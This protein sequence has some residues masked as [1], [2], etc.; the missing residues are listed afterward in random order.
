MADHG[1]EKPNLKIHN[2]SER[3]DKWY[4]GGGQRLLFA[5]PFPLWLTTP[6]FWDEAQFYEFRLSPIFTL[7]LL[8]E[9]EKPIALEVVERRWTPA[10]F[11]ITYRAKNFLLRESR[12]LLPPDTLASVFTVKNSRRMPLA[13]HAILWNVEDKEKNSISL[14]KVESDIVSYRMDVAG[15][16]WTA[17]S[18]SPPPGSPSSIL[19]YSVNLSERTAI[20]P[21]WYLTP[22][23]ESFHQHLPNQIQTTGV[24]PAGLLYIG[25]HRSIHIPGGERITFMA[26]RSFSLTLNG[27]MEAVKSARRQSDPVE[28]ARTWWQS[29]FSR[30]PTFSCSNPFIQASYLHRV[31]GLWLN[32]V[33]GGLGTIRHP[34]V[35]EGISYFRSPIAYSAPAQVFE[36]RWMKSSEIPWGILLNFIES[37]KTDGSFYGILRLFAPPEEAFYHANWGRALL[38]LYAIH[39]DPSLLNIVYRALS[40]YAKYFDEVRDL[41]KSGLY[42]VVNHFETGQE[43]MSRYTAVHPTADAEN[44]GSVFRLK[45]VDATV[46]IYELKRAL[47]QAA[48]LLKKAEETEKWNRQADAIREA[49]R[50]RMWNQR[51]GMFSD[52]DPSTGQKTNIK[53]AI[54]F[55]PYL[56]DIV[57]KPHVRRLARHLFNPEEFWTPFPVPATSIDDRT[58]SPTPEWKGKRHNCPWNG[59]V[60]PM[61]NSHIADALG[62]VAYHIDPRF[63][64]RLA[65]FLLRYLKMLFW[66]EDVT[67]PNCYEHYNPFTGEPSAYRGIDDYMHSWVADLIIQYIAGF[68]P[69]IERRFTVDP[70]PIPL[71]RLTIENIPFQGHRITIKRRRDEQTVYVDGKRVASPRVG[72]PFHHS[73]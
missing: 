49:I 58:F 1:V 51:T 57:R 19:S 40:D 47:A 20:Q 66:D 17:M 55:Y 71:S 16:V 62:Y 72:K 69:S 39:P 33:P 30:F 38:K 35:C 18:L 50:L 26:C 36:T 53:A 24:S 37:Q 67:R 63:K 59:R 44:W 29:L 56:T 3:E 2:L 61:V 7:T 4:L 22:W 41:E 23:V 64:P 45:G 27:A 9:K 28:V 65:E 68:H 6:G 54:C 13:L 8:D 10:E 70:L 15:G 11:S 60:W 43:F 32:T 52:I 48:A 42:D 31:Y 46:Y 21:H 25:L 5:P 73:L 14:L 12:I 34:A